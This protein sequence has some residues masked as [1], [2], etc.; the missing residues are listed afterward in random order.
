VKRARVATKKVAKPHKKSSHPAPGPEASKSDSFPIVGIGASA[1]GLEAFK[2]L[3][4]SLPEKAGMAYVLVP[5]LDP[6]HHSVVAEILSRFTKI[7]IAEVMGGMPAE[8]DHIYVIPPN[9]TMGIA[10]GKFALF[11]RDATHSPHLPI[12][13]FLTALAN[14]RGD[15]AIG[16]ILSGSDGTQ[17]CIA[18]KVAGGITFAQDEKPAKY[19]DMPGNAIRGGAS[20][21]CCPLR[22]SRKNWLGS[23]ATPMPDESRTSR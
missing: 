18:I 5:H 16:I 14:D 8:R 1:G 15:Q 3:L 11:E 21:L 10:D 12:D 2:E 7:P 4:T 6:A 22:A 23:A 17:G 20:I 19:L 9:K 13:Y